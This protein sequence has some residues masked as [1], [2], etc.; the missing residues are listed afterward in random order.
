MGFQDFVRWILPKEDH[1]YTYLE[2]LAT[3]SHEAALAL[4][5]W[6]DPSIPTKSVCDAV[7]V[8]EHKADGIVVQLE[9]GLARTFVTPLDRED[10][11]RLGSELDDVVDLSNLAA[12]AIVLYGV[13]RP[14]KEMTALIDVL[15]ESTAVLKDSVPMLRHHKYAELVEAARTL[16][17][18]EKDADRAYRD[19]ISRLFHDD[20]IDAKTAMKQREVLEDL[21]RAV[22][23]CD[24]VAETL[25]NLA[26]K[27]G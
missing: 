19:A 25:S 10:L 15:V 5:K 22:D 6:K 2:S 9:D 1:F 24:H 26:V 7:Q 23:H 3:A 21:E 18:L 11:H 27:H 12:R 14:T 13:D 16:R 4:T 20:S 17:Q 8:I